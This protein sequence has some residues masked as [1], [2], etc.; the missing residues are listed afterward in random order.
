M[1]NKPVVCSFQA[2]NGTIVCFNKPL[3]KIRSQPISLDLLLTDDF[4]GVESAQN[5]YTIGQ[6]KGLVTADFD[7]EPQYRVDWFDDRYGISFVTQYCSTGT[8][9]NGKTPLLHVLEYI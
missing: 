9:K 5:Q 6:F 2:H 4:V 7:D 8:S 1:T 3:L